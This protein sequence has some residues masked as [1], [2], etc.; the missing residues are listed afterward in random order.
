MPQPVDKPKLQFD[1]CVLDLGEAWQNVAKVGSS[2]NTVQTDPIKDECNLEFYCFKVPVIW[3]PCKSKNLLLYYF[4]SIAKQ[5][6]SATP[7]NITT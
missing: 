7:A 1:L 5:T 3:Q 6:P 4:I 2:G